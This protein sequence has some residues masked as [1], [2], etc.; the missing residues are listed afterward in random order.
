MVLWLVSCVPFCN[1][2]ND[3]IT[4]P[5]PTPP[6]ARARR[7]RLD[8]DSDLDESSN[9]VLAP[10]SGAV[11]AA[12]VPDARTRELALRRS[13][14]EDTRRGVRASCVQQ[15][16]QE[17]FDRLYGFFR[18]LGSEEDEDQEEGGRGEGEEEDKLRLFPDAGNL[19]GPSP[20]VGLG[21]QAVNRCVRG[22][23]VAL[24]EGDR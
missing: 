3:P 22:T 9:T 15:I 19:K 16:S 18:T 5:T 4:P 17:K 24:C 10:G 2:A 8:L 12:A 20:G 11:V 14:L 23:T 13:R 6:R 7:P 21:S 1:P